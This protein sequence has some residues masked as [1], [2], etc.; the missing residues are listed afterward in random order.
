MHQCD[1]VWICAN[2]YYANNKYIYM[3]IHIREFKNVDIQSCLLSY[4]HFNTALCDQGLSFSKTFP[5][6]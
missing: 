1:K 5:V 6:A 3:N 4:L 2:T